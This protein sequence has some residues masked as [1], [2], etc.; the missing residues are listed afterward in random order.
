VESLISE[1]GWGRRLVAVT[2]MVSAAE[3]LFAAARDGVMR[4]TPDAGPVP[5]LVFPF[6]G[7]NYR[8]A[9]SKLWSMPEFMII[10]LLSVLIL[11]L[12]SF[13]AAMVLPGRR[14][15][16]AGAALLIV[17]AVRTDWRVVIWP[18]D[19]EGQV[20]SFAGVV[21]GS[22]WLNPSRVLLSA[23]VILWG[24][25]LGHLLR[26]ALRRRAGREGGE[27]PKQVAGRSVA[28]ILLAVLMLLG[29]EVAF[30]VARDLSLPCTPDVGLLSFPF[31]GL[32]R[33]T[34][35]M[36]EVTWRCACPAFVVSL[37]CLVALGLFLGLFARRRGDLLA[38][39]SFLAVL[40]LRDNVSLYIEWATLAPMS[41]ARALLSSCATI[42]LLSLGWA[43]PALTARLR[44]STRE[45]SGE[46]SEQRACS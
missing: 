19:S 13:V 33:G 3:A 26:R 32:A 46:T 1:T 20:A 16:L 4:G 15:A 5:L 18:A 43:P 17:L 24:S 42:G 9:L 7:L 41:L 6:F 12:V 14:G 39:V 21:G 44:R 40:A 45:T 37:C 2:V 28:A 36:G 25:G 22:V 34:P 27:P 8:P 38:G 10:S 31:F 11:L 30:M 23:L 35:E 29:L